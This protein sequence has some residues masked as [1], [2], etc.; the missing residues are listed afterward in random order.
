LDQH[1]ESAL[2]RFEVEDTGIGLT[3]EAQKYLFQ[4]FVQADGSTT[5]RYGGT[6]L[7]LSICKRLVELMG[8]E[9]G[10][11]SLR[12][13]GSRFWF[14]VPLRRR[15]QEAVQEERASDSRPVRVLI[16]DQAP[17]SRMIVENYLAGANIISDAAVSSEECLSKLHKN[18]LT[19]Q[20]FDF[21]VVN[22]SNES[23]DYLALAKQINAND[24]LATT[25]LIL[26]L[27][28]DKR[29]RESAALQ[30]GFAACVSKP[31]KQQ[32]L[33]ATVVRLMAGETAMTPEDPIDTTDSVN[34]EITAVNMMVVPA[35][36]RQILVAEDNPVMQELALR[37]LKKMGM[38]AHAVKNG[39]EAVQAVA[40]N[41]YALILMDCQ[42]P[43]MDGFEATRTIRKEESVSGKHIPIIAMTASAMTGDR[44]HCIASG[45]DDYLSKPVGKHQLMAV[46]ERWLNAPEFKLQ[47]EEPRTILAAPL[48]T[49]PPIDLIKLKEL[50]GEGSLSELLESFVAEAQKLYASCLEKIKEKDDRALVAEAHTLKGL[51][52]VMTAEDLEKLSLAVEQAGRT[53]SW[54]QAAETC[55]RLGTDLNVVT[56]FINHLLGA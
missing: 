8:G 23:I 51:C 14:T 21:A 28:F 26:L 27:P 24:A 52:A 44:E 46:L 5:R 36:D 32:Q 37:Q 50:Y 22:S 31:V 38:V 48:D 6:G 54:E 49:T 2:V 18:F 40:N 56:N 30:G 35:S 10:V 45:M 4:P 17:A 1:S 47:K 3:E 7:G 11:S 19:Q 55:K 25:K 34:Q 15:L 42:M 20:S 41:K 33:L 13:E 39:K 53:S 9:I 16:V 12:G 29:D 43:E